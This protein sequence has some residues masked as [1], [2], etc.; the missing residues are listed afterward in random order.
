MADFQKMFDVIDEL[1]SF[2]KSEPLLKEFVPAMSEVHEQARAVAGGQRHVPAMQKTSTKTIPDR[3][4]AQRIIEIMSKLPQVDPATDDRASVL[5]GAQLLGN[6]V[7]AITHAV[8]GSFP[9]VVPRD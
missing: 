6:L 1:N 4:L 2:V 3:A 9:D 5:A 8:Y 7:V